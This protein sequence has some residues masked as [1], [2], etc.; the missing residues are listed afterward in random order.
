MTIESNLFV[1]ALRKASI[2]GKTTGL[3]PLPTSWRNSNNEPATLVGTMKPK[4]FVLARSGTGHVY[5]GVKASSGMAQPETQW[6]EHLPLLRDQVEHFRS[7]YRL[8]T[9]LPDYEQDLQRAIEL[10]KHLPATGRHSE[11]IDRIVGQQA[12]RVVEERVVKLMLTDRASPQWTLNFIWVV[13]KVS[14]LSGVRFGQAAN[15]SA[16]LD[17]LL[18]ALL[19]SPSMNAQRDWILYCSG[20]ICQRIF[21]GLP[22]FR[23]NSNLDTWRMIIVKRTM[24]TLQKREG[25]QQRTVITFTDLMQPN[26]AGLAAESDEVQFDP[27]ATDLTPEEQAD[28]HEL[29]VILA[30]MS[31]KVLTKFPKIAPIVELLLNGLR[32]REVAELL[33]LEPATVHQAYY[34]WKRRMRQLYKRYEPHYEPSRPSQGAKRSRATPKPPKLSG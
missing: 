10:L 7:V 23:F 34:Q 6:E 3:S 17:E 25:H 28:R 32:S 19:G 12:R 29:E 14:L 27:P 22:R 13:Q 1:T 30:E 4:T 9:R 26:Q 21:M 15:L 24:Y 2:V 11:E 33:E 16:S 8:P 18:D 31:W 20:E 5:A